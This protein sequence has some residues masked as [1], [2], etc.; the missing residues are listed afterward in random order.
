MVQSLISS[1]RDFLELIYPTSC[2]G[3]CGRQG[4]VLC[5]ACTESFD[6]IDPL[7]T[8]PL[9]GR[10][11]GRS[12]ICGQCTIHP[13]LFHSGF[14]GFS[15]EG[16]L[17]EALHDFKFNG[18][19][20]VGR[21]LVSLLK[22]K[23]S[24]L[25]DSF[26]VVVPLPVTEKRLRSRGFNQSFIISEEIGRITKKS[27]D[28]RTLFKIRET[29]DQF[30]LSREERRK[31]VRGAFAVVARPTND[32]RG[33]RLLLVDDLFTT[34]NTAGAACTVL[35]S[36]KPAAISLFALARTPE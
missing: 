31:N 17:R 32:L 13:P 21:E 30:T 22:E 9:C 27:I 19:K 28:Y 1:G 24:L 20:D 12:A 2:G 15:F 6:P 5:P 11:L 34:G 36:L 29:Q 18:R 14:F 35:H 8:C 33:K 26:D 16:P 23:V 7:V 4:A 10:W 3:G 25:R